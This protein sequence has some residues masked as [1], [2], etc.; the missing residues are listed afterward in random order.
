MAVLA[1]ARVGLMFSEKDTDPVAASSACVGIPT[2]CVG[3]T[4]VADCRWV[5]RELFGEP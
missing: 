1:D 4:V 3:H 5:S 2:R